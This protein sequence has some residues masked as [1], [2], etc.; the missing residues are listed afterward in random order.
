ML[1]VSVF[2]FFGES[3]LQSISCFT[4]VFNDQLII[5]D[6]TGEEE[7]ETSKNEAKEVVTQTEDQNNLAILQ[8]NHL[9]SIAFHKCNLKGSGDFSE[10]TTPPPEPVIG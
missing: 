7:N 1:L 8:H 10:V 9:N 2:T 4:N 3:A 5:V 6:F